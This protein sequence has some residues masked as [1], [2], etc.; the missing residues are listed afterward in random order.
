MYYCL[1]SKIERSVAIMKI[2]HITMLSSLIL[3]AGCDGKK[4]V[5]VDAEC[6]FSSTK[7]TAVHYTN[8]NAS[9]YARD[10][11]GNKMSGW[12]WVKRVTDSVSD[13]TCHEVKPD[14]N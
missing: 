2:I 10:F 13:A 5:K 4:E 9:D 1:P 3:I 11:Q 6:Y 7:S 8:G 12:A 14:K